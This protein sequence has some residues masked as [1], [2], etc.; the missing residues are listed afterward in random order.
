M[1][2]DLFLQLE[3]KVQHAV[4]VIELL[5]LQLEE[6]EE[7]NLALKAEH[8]KWRSDLSSMIKRFDD[9]DSIPVR[10]DDTPS[11]SELFSQEREEEVSY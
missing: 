11:Q 10:E 1:S 4:E 9:I 5:R 2:A 6:L 8:E 7:E 3:K